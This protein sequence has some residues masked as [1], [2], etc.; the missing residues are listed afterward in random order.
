MYIV[1]DRGPGFGCLTTTFIIFLELECLVTHQVCRRRNEN[2]ISDRPDNKTSHAY[3]DDRYEVGFWKLVGIIG[4][5][6]SYPRLRIPRGITEPRFNRIQAREQCL[7][8]SRN[9]IDRCLSITKFRVD[10]PGSVEFE[11]GQT[12]RS[13][14]MGWRSI[15][16]EDPTQGG[17]LA[18]SPDRDAQE[19]SSVD[20][21]SFRALCG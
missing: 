20:G 7:E 13:T 18:K 12:R 4:C 6:S 21:T 16:R 9:P 2:L 5:R 3:L 11:Q 8:M 14:S 10:V 1:L 17:L 15:S 19:T